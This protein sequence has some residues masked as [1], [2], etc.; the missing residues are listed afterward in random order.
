[1]PYLLGKGSR[2][3]GLSFRIPERYVPR[4]GGAQG[5]KKVH[6]ELLTKLII[7][8]RI[9]TTYWRAEVAKHQAESL[10]N[11]VKDGQPEIIHYVREKLRT[12]EAIEKV[13]TELAVR[14]MRKE[15]DFIDI[16]R[17][18]NRGS[19][20][21]FMA[22]VELQGNPFPSLYPAL[23]LGRNPPVQKASAEKEDEDKPMRWKLVEYPDNPLPV[24]I[25]KIP[26]SALPAVQP[27][28]PAEE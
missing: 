4:P 24:D 10:I 7:H 11:K 15:K 2:Q 3:L 14:F 20:G 18:P 23:G 28:P 1:M 19:D 17:I 9:I 27:S 13:C 6:S 8:E 26:L 5:K 21:A 12:G 16:Y 25:P 22:I